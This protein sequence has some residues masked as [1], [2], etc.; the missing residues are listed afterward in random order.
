[1]FIAASVAVGLTLCALFVAVAG[2]ASGSQVKRRVNTGASVEG[3]AQQTQSAL[4]PKYPSMRS[5]PASPAAMPE[6]NI[7]SYNKY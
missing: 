5:T 2:L 6:E 7:F 1:M 4:E 3:K